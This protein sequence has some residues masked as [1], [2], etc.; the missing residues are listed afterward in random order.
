MRVLQTILFCIISF[1][2]Y[3]QAPTLPPTNLGLANVYDG[4]AGKAGF[5]IQNPKAQRVLELMID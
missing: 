4:V 5:M 1:F 3:A 2:V